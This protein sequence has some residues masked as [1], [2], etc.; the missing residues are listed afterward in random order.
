MPVLR[1]DIRTL[2]GQCKT[3]QWSP[4][5]CERSIT[6]HVNSS[7]NITKKRLSAVPWA[8]EIAASWTGS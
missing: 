7:A 2:E 5:I 6:K 1:A 8:P 4:S 3:T